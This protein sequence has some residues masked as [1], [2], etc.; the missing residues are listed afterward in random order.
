[1]EDEYGGTI[2]SLTDEE[3][4]ELELEHVDTIEYKGAVYM[5]FFPVHEGSEDGGEPEDEEEDGLIILKS[6]TV[7]GEEQLATLDTEEELEEVYEQFMVELFEDEE[8]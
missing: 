5:A 1:M 7:D 2:I 8:T 3:G 6:V 4:N